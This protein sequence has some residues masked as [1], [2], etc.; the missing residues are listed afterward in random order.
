M[1]LFLSSR[2][3]V[4]AGHVSPKSRADTTWPA[5]LTKPRRTMEHP[6]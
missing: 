6:G 4:R 2:T 5:N 3:W 1:K